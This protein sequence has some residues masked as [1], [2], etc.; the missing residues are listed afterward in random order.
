MTGRAVHRRA[1]GALA[2]MAAMV[3]CAV[4]YAQSNRW[5]DPYDKGRKAFEAG[6]YAEAVP[7]L[8]RAVAAE[9]KAA[10]NKIIE[11]VF[12][13]DYFPYYYLALAYAELRQWNKASE[14]LDKARPLLKR[15]QTA[16]FNEAESKIKLALSTPS[17][18]P[19]TPP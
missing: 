12:R 4:L 9:P 2:A 13:T 8:E 15:E 18:P 14:N 6:K 3:T 11:G 1:V 10:P 16:K 19:R 7:L 5:Y 17:T